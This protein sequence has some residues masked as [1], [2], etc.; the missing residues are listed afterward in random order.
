MTGQPQ[1][2]WIV[3]PAHNERE[4]I[5]PTLE[6]LVRQR[7]R[8]FTAV[9]VDNASTDGTAE[10]V[11]AFA[12]AHPGFDLRVIDEPEKGTGA[13]SDTGMRY[14]IDQGATLL[15]RT[16]ADCLPTTGWTTAVR[17][18]FDAGLEFAGGQTRSRTDDF[19]VTWR[20]RM[21]VAAVLR[22]GRVMA[23]FRKE[24]RGPEFLGP[25]L[26]VAGS[27]T[28]I[29]A[30][31]YKRCGGYPRTA[32]EDAHE[33][34][35]LMNRVRQV[36]RAYGRRRDMVIHMSLRRVKAWGLRNTV[37]WYTDHAYRGEVVD[38]R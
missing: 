36:T 25:Y 10:V 4:W 2:L 33:D 8:R 34:R 15:A 3:V 22:L 6:A 29:T 5:T 26:L 16:D 13:A 37:S 19:R 35:E 21:A 14:A 28:A 11:R 27:N 30:D 1:H 18:A 7:D 20:E 38:V 23:R 17:R 24:R 32:I 31:L 12:A 9:V